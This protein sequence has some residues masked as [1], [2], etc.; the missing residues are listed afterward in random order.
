MQSSGKV[1]LL[2]YLIIAYWRFALKY[3]LG[4]FQPENFL[5]D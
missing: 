4:S 3:S 2:N 1:L 5:I